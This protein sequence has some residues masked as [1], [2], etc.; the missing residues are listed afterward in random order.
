MV[1]A[2]LPKNIPAILEILINS[3]LLELILNESWD[4]INKVTWHFRNFFPRHQSVLYVP[5]PEP[6]PSSRPQAPGASAP[7]QGTMMGVIPGTPQSNAPSSA[8]QNVYLG[9][10]LTSQSLQ[11][12]N[13]TS[14]DNPVISTHGISNGK[15]KVWEK[16]NKASARE[17]PRVWGKKTRYRQGRAQDMSKGTTQGIPKGEPKVLVKEAPKV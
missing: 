16:I 10:R 13:V 11:Q 1:C 15:P 14:T 4:F 3:F 7:T 12:G 9:G 17:S 6:S 5:S 8:N 2:L